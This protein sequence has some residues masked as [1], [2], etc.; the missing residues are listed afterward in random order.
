MWCLCVSVSFLHTF[1]VNLHPFIPFDVPPDIV[2][3]EFASMVSI[4]FAHQ[5][6]HS[7]VPFLLLIANIQDIAH[8][9]RLLPI[10]AFGS[11]PCAIF[12]LPF[13]RNQKLLGSR[14]LCGSL[15]LFLWLFVVCCLSGCGGGICSCIGVVCSV[16]GCGR[17]SGCGGLRLFLVQR[18][19]VQFGLEIIVWNFHPFF[20][21]HVGEIFLR[22]FHL[23]VDGINEFDLTELQPHMNVG[24]VFF[25]V[26]V[27]Q[28]HLIFE[29][30]GHLFQSII[31]REL[32]QHDFAFIAG[33][34]LSRLI[35]AIN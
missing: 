30:F 5:P 25:L 23:L 13:N 2:H 27:F 18:N 16:V 26:V 9:D 10:I 11:R 4:R 34:D 21:V 17:V 14:W 29:I 6:D 15:R 31:W 19:V 1:T 20:R 22:H 33:V 35:I 12:L 24:C 32:L 7:L 28:L 3:N 8:C